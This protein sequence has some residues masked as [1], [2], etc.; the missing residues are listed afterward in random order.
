MQHEVWCGCSTGVIPTTL[1]HAERTCL[2]SLCCHVMR[3][4]VDSEQ[5]YP[6]SVT[7]C[8][9]TH[10]V[11][12]LPGCVQQTVQHCSMTVNQHSPPLP[13]HSICTTDLRWQ[14]ATL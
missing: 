4:L 1:S 9:I 12:G 7:V 11:V 2:V 14:P 10:S 3:W 5:R 13:G 8:V 6:D